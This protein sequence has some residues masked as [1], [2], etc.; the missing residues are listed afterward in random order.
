MFLNIKANNFICFD[1]TALNSYEIEQ[2]SDKFMMNLSLIH[3]IVVK[4]C[5][6]KIHKNGKQIELRYQIEFDRFVEEG[7][8]NHFT[9]FF[10]SKKDKEFKRIFKIVKNNIYKG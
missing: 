5:A 8:L 4:Q 9:L 7:I 2:V 10:T 6:V 3:Q 1:K